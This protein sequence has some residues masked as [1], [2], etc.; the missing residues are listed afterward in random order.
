MTSR[1]IDSQKVT[2]RDK[3]HT[4]PVGSTSKPSLKN[5]SPFCTGVFEPDF[6]AHS[7]EQKATLL[8]TSHGVRIVAN[9][10]N[11]K[12]GKKG[13]TD[14]ECFPITSIKTVEFDSKAPR[15]IDHE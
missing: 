2:V 6:D 7:F 14:V 15:G 10:D 13:N 8:F 3:G 12:N 5:Y 9:P 4:N 1:A 11:G